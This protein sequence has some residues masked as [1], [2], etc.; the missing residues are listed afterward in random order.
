MARHERAEAEQAQADADAEIEAVAVATETPTLEADDVSDSADD[1]AAPEQT[2][3]VD[4][5]S[6]EPASG[7]DEAADVP[8]AEAPEPSAEEAP[9]PTPPAEPEPPRV[10]TRTRRRAASR[11]AGPPTTVTAP[12]T[13][14]EG[15]GGP[16]DAATSGE[17]QTPGD[18]T[19]ALHVPV[20]R[21]GGARK[22]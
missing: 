4:E 22:R 3:T 5:T 7:A 18:E 21:K 15:S 8:A 14:I 6:A 12:D 10:V 17:P 1:T 9:E 11:P 13:R 20:K 16:E 2:D 19:P